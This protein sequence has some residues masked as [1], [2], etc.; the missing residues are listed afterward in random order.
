MTI[1]TKTVAQK[2][3]GP[4]AETNRFNHNIPQDRNFWN[5]FEYSAAGIDIGV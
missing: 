1:D 4:S 2:T 3:A 5:Y